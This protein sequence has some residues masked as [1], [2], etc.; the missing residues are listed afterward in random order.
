MNIQPGH[1]SPLGAIWEGEGVNF[2]IFSE[3][4][5]AVEL[6]LFESPAARR[7]EV[8]T[9][10]PGRTDAIWHGYIERLRP[11]QLYGYRIHGAY[12]PIAGHRFNPHKIVLD[13]YAKGIGRPLRWEDRLF[14]YR[15]GDSE[16][17][18]SFDSRDSAA[19]A[20]LATVLE[21][22][23]DWGDDHPPR[24]PWSQTVIY[25]M[26]VKGYTM[27]H[28]EIPKKYRGTYLALAS[29]SVI[30]HLKQLGVTAVEL[31]PIHHHLDERW[32]V[33]KGKVNY[34]GYNTLSFFAPDTRFATQQRPQEA[35]SEFKTMVRALHAAGIEVILDVVYN[36]TAEGNH[37]GPTLS[38]RGIDNVS[39]YHLKKGHERF[40]EDF[41]GCGNTL[42][43]QHPGVLQLLLD[44]LRY[45]V[46]EVHVDGFRFD[47][48][49]SLSR[50]EGGE[51]RINTFFTSLREDPIL[52]Q[53]KLIAEPWDR[54]EGGYRLG[55]FPMGWVEWNDQY[56]NA[57]RRFW[58]GEEGSLPELA[59][60]LCGSS[61]LYDKSGRG[62]HASVNFITC[63]D[64]FTLEDLVSFNEKHNEAN[65]EDNHD[66]ET[67]NFSWNCGI[68]GFTKNQKSQALRRR[69][70][71][72][73]VAT[74]F[75]SQGVPM[76]RGGD[77]LGQSQRGNN[78]AYCQDN[79]ISWTDWKWTEEKKEF[80]KF[81]ERVIH[82]WRLQPLLHRQTFF[83]GRA[84][85]GSS[86]K[87]VTW[88]DGRG[89]EMTPEIWKDAHNH[90]LGVMIGEKENALLLLLNASPHSLSFPFPAPEE[91]HSWERIFDTHDAYQE[92][93]REVFQKGENYFLNGF[94]LA[95]FQFVS[96]GGRR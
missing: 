49:A 26:H 59:T 21:T 5:T 65:G 62:P 17:D 31:L 18:L 75:L 74:L 32:L 86:M 35:L 66:G 69:Q 34:W 38:F 12:E 56:R 87:D 20:P 33:E 76:I 77:E 79:D 8:K 96:N 85:P 7:E 19:F 71:R 52:S 82:L 48:A 64:G 60:R 24:I 91:G 13:P 4:A 61:D 78:N 54:G 88:F 9:F 3:H 67:H 16:K 36:H 27:R 22:D 55:N 80:L 28:P 95:L 72:N 25:E 51:D 39:Y 57:V 68:E 47:L 73:L 44:S 46:R 37:L 15:V 70:K 41:T 30:R 50:G 1:S 89:N 90:F 84:F 23:F 92:M 2:A 43:M 42:N 10:L 83:K 58:R 81:F 29:E 93:N 94:T 14:G 6:C 11:G 45:W 53:V 40:Y 63:H